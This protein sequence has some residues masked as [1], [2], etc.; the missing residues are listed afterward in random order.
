MVKYHFVITMLGA[1]LFCPPALGDE[2][3]DVKAARDHY[4]KGTR[5]FDLGHYKEAVE[6]YEEAY[7]AKDDPAL[8]FNIGQA[9]RLAGDTENA[10]RVY[11]AYLRRVPGAPNRREVEARISE[12]GRVQEQHRREIESAPPERAFGPSVPPPVEPSPPPPRLAPPPVEPS[13]PAL[14]APAPRPL[15]KRPWF[16][17]AV[18]GG[19]AV[20]VTA[21][22]LGVALGSPAPRASATFGTVA[23]N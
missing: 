4:R 21:V 17:V 2:H 9:Y 14:V 18:G 1:A 7:R 23:G 16:W 5:L 19:A 22:A 6:E 3:D 13:A 10:I 12:L 15:V 8:L 11:K 20:V